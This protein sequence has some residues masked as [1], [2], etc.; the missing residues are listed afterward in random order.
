[1]H[2]GETWKSSVD[3][4]T[5]VMSRSVKSDLYQMN[6]AILSII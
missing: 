3:C 1:M 4:A 6:L 2:L 5:T